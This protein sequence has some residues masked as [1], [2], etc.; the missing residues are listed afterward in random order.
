MDDAD[1]T[2]ALL[3]AA[4]HAADADDD[5]MDAASEG[6]DADAYV[7]DDGAATRHTG[8][9]RRWRAWRSVAAALDVLDAPQT[10]RSPRRRA[11]EVERALLLYCRSPPACAAATTTPRRDGRARGRRA[12]RGAGACASA[13]A[14]PAR[15]PRVAR[16]GRR[17]AVR[18]L[19]GGGRLVKGGADDVTAGG[20]M[21]AA[22]AEQDGRAAAVCLHRECGYDASPCWKHGALTDGCKC[23]AKGGLLALEAGATR[24]AA[25]AAARRSTSN[26]RRLRLRR[27]RASATRA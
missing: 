13:A 17:Q 15:P 1:A 11:G 4:A 19:G 16:G 20:E 14:D 22:L 24:G 21:S 8:E 23:H 7:D 6:V 18:D 26:V 5:D 27:P 10:A 9:A 12:R 2:A 3:T 25:T